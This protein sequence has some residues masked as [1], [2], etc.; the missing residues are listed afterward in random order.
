MTTQSTT[1]QGMTHIDGGEMTEPFCQHCL[2]RPASRK[3]RPRDV[4]ISQP[5]G[6][7][8]KYC[9]NDCMTAACYG[10]LSEYR[11]KEA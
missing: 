1:Y 10:R 11:K 5:S 4:L 8:R 2:I 3:V 7:F 9:S 6:G